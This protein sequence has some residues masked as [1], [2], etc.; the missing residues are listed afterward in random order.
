MW[1]QANPS[2]R[3]ERPMHGEHVHGRLFASS[4]LGISNFAAQ[5]YYDS[6]RRH[7]C[8]QA[9]REDAIGSIVIAAA[10][11]LR[12]PCR[13]E[14]MRTAK[15]SW[16]RLGGLRVMESITSSLLQITLQLHRS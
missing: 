10:I 16:P 6:A 7:R 2:A 14:G 12:E 1:R 9:S 5:H 8:S 13:R 3:G 4:R 11:A 15:Q